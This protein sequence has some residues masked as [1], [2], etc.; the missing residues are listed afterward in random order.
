MRTHVDR[1]LVPVLTSVLASL[2]ATGCGPPEGRVDALLVVP[3]PTI[4]RGARQEPTSASPTGVA[5]SPQGA[6]F[7]A[8]AA[9]GLIGQVVEGNKWLTFARTG[10]RPMGLAFAASGDLYV[11]DSGRGAVLRITPWGQLT[12]LADHL[13]ESKFVSPDQIAIGP[14]GDVYVTD[15]GASRVYRVSANGEVRI[16]ADDLHGPSGVLVSTT[17]GHVYVAEEMGA[18]WRFSPDGTSKDLFATLPDEG[19]PSGMALDEKGSLYVA[20]HGSGKVSVLSPSGKL[21]NTYSIPGPSVRAL[22]FGGTDMKTLYVTESETGAVYQ[23]RVAHRSQ[24]LPWEPD[25]LVRITDPPDGAILNRHDGEQT[26][27][28]LRI[29]VRGLSKAPGPVQVNGVGV[30]ATNGRFEIQITLR[31]RRTR[32]AAETPDGSRDSVTLIWDRDSFPRYRVSTDD[33]IRF[34]KDIAQN[35]DRY[36][37]IF[38]NPYL[39]LWQ[40]MHR[41][42]GTKVHFNIYYETEGFDLSEMPD[43]FRD[44]WLENRDWIRLSFHARSASRKRPYIHASAEE[45]KADYRLVTREI[46]RFAGDELL[47]PVTTVHFGETTLSA[48]RALREEGIRVLVG[49]FWTVNDLPSVSYYLSRREVLHLAQRDYWQDPAENLL[50]I[51]HDIVINRMELDD[52]EPFLERL[53]ADPHRSEVVELMIHEQYFYPDYPA[54]QPDYRERVE[55]AIGWVTSRRY[56]SVFYEEGFLGTG[57]GG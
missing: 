54:Y 20:R 30:S 31:E 3:P 11:A 46:E 40:D 19:Q 16:V 55:R 15:P 28:G 44:E 42:Y 57:R 56:E 26:S 50:F 35:A 10:G 48:A 1:R 7:I 5:T 4:L 33:N 21:T 12:I 51:R 2:V 41:K 47:S 52:I 45:I 36:S 27:E 14:D 24:R 32:V 9:N 38:E 23:L 49:Y 34:L 8:S 37:S 18:I 29:T 25:K 53:A 43:S 39:A 22:A 17:S 13:E 6:P